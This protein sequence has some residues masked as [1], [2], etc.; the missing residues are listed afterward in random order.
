MSNIA[1]R[2]PVEFEKI[3]SVAMKTPG[4]KINR[5]VFLRKELVRFYSEDIVNKAIRFNPAKA[6]I[7][8]N[9]IDKIADQ[10]IR[11]ETLKVTSISAVASLPGGLAAVGAASA[12]MVSY[13]AFILRVLQKL[14]YLYGFDEFELNEDNIDDATMHYLLVFLGVMFGVQGSATVLRSI[15]Q[16]M[17]KNVQKNL[18]KKAL[19]KGTVYP[20]V[21]K[22]AT[23][24]GYKMTK[25]VFADGVASTIP[26][27]SAGLSGGLTYIMF[28]PNCK[29]L[30]N[31]LRQYDLCNPKY[32]IE[33]IASECVTSEGCNECTNE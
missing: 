7:E 24:I 16:V 20:M 5:K 23:T 3:L 13:F 15:A 22:I 14:A 12:D 32:Y 29:R 10:C 26:V 33:A 2:N 30:K 6:G 31:Q 27:L 18:A 4:V 25:Q 9:L 17:A 19:T 8:R 28:K 21:K 11:Y 1:V